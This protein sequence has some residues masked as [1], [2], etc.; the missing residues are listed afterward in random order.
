MNQPDQ[1]IMI[2]KP[3]ELILLEYNKGEKINKAI[4]E[5]K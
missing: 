3:N 1:M 2:F 4:I 5:H